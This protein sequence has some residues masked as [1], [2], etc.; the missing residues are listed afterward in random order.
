MKNEQWQK[1]KNYAAMKPVDSF[2]T[3][4]I[5]DSP[6]MPGYAGISTIDFITM[7]DIWFDT[8]MK[9]KKDFPDA[10][11]LADFWVEYGMGAES[12]GF[13]C[14]IEFFAGSPPAVEKIIPSVDDVD[15]IDR[16]KVPNPKRN[17]L[18]PLILSQYRNMLPRIKDVGE[19]VKVVAARGPFTVASYIMGITDF[20]MLVK[21]EPDCAR[22]LLKKTTAL[23]KNWLEAQLETVKDA[24]AI[25]VLD[26][27]TGFF[28]KQD[29][30]EF[31]HPYL[32]EIFDSFPEQMK[33]F[34]NDTDNPVCYPYLEELGVNIFNFTHLQEI[35][36]VRDLCG[37][38]VCLLGNVPPISLI[39]GTPESIYEAGKKCIADFVTHTGGSSGLILGLGG[40][41]SMNAT[42][43][44]IDALIRAAKDFKIV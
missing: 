35:T 41:T 11:L 30:L 42:K 2:D 10:L 39:D 37:N 26:D 14:P 7:P 19:S 25:M 38:K 34:H 16:I 23:V 27:V 44:N 33:I 43:E 18:M 15:L 9:V 5:V 31:I 12:S 36:K 24:E 21:L 20:V 6:W 29:Y 28:S 1:L 13:G 17:G 3:C 32:K 22:R 4:L 40:G 8:Y